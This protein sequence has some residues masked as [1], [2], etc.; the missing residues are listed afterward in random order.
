MNGILDLLKSKRL[1]EAQ[2]SDSFNFQENDV[3][4]FVT[5]GKGGFKAGE[6]LRVVK[7]E[8]QNVSGRKWKRASIQ[9]PLDSPNSFDVYQVARCKFCSREIPFGSPRRTKTT[10][11][12]NGTIVKLDGFSPEGQLQLSNG[13]SLSPDWGHIDYGVTITS[14]ASQGKTYDRVLVSQSQMSFP[15]SSPEQIYVTA[16]RGT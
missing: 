7:V 13:R 1:T 10:K 14:H 3:V 5:R 12:Y 9:V 2:R 11:L 4:E 16:S 15:A 6:R 8:K